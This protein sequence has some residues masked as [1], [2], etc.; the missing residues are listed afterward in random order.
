ME[1]LKQ[2][3]EGIINFINNE[4]DFE[5]LKVMQEIILAPKTSTHSAWTN[6]MTYEE[7]FVHFKEKSQSFKL[8]RP[9]LKGPEI[10]EKQ[11]ILV[12]D[13][14][15]LN[16][17]KF[18]IRVSGIER[19]NMAVTRNCIMYDLEQEFTKN[20]YDTIEMWENSKK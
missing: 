9:E 20:V 12:L 8:Y 11:I 7:W 10:S 13:Y 15:K 3:T 16:Y 14:L 19:P 17:D 5:L 1:N 4:I 2:K 18:F 6:C